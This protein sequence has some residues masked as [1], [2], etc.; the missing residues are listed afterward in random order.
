MAHNFLEKSPTYCRKTPN[1]VRL[2][3]DTVCRML[4]EG[5]A[6]PRGR[7]PEILAA[8]RSLTGGEKVSDA[9]VR[10]DAS[11]FRAAFRFLTT[12]PEDQAKYVSERR[13][14]NP[15]QMV[16]IN[17]LLADNLRSFEDFPQEDGLPTV[18]HADH[19]DVIENEIDHLR[20]LVAMLTDDK[21]K[22]EDSVKKLEEE[23]QQLEQQLESVR[24][25][26]ASDTERRNHVVN[27]DIP[28]P[29][30]HHHEAIEALRRRLPKVY[31]WPHEKGK[32]VAHDKFLKALAGFDREQQKQVLKHVHQLAEK[33]PAYAS[34]QTKKQ[35]NG[36]IENTPQGSFASRA[37][38]E[39]RFTWEKKPG[40]I[41]LLF[42][43]RRGD[44]GW[45]ES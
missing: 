3:R 14:N 6:V 4:N 12:S 40:L 8:V 21:A 35:Y 32:V 16:G 36:S 23:K 43:V 31:Q 28:E 27:K 34:L 5:Y 42:V 33:G 39:L 41:R 26:V 30:N 10:N 45:S 29:S 15:P 13:K 25:I 11:V 37:S 7:F 9:T 18:N 2:R 17:A 1:H 38:S 24:S 22:L 19:F 20:S 44:T